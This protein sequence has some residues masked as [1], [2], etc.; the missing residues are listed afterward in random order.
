MADLYK[1]LVDFRGRGAYNAIK[2]Q[3]RRAR[4]VTG[5]VTFQRAVD[6]GI[7][8]ENVP[9]NGLVRAERTATGSVAPDG[10]RTR[11]QGGAYGMYA[12]RVGAQRQLGWYRRIS[13]LSQ[14][15]DRA[16]SFLTG[17]M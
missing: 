3:N 7:T 4:G 2:Q 8:A 6:G 10:T 14:R 16:V 9:A 13:V 12:E 17:G 1:L 15:R 11:Y 5:P